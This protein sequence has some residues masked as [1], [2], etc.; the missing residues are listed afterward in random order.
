MP[1][2][3]VNDQFVPEGGVVVGDDGSACSAEAVRV[4]AQDAARRG[5]PLHIVRC[6][7]MRTAPSPD[8]ATP[9]YV[10]PLSDWEAAVR[11]EM[12][13]TWGARLTRDAPGVPVELHPVHAKPAQALVTAS[14][15]ADLVV[16]GFRGRGG[17]RER[18]LGSVAAHV[19]H[20][21]ACPVLLV[22]WRS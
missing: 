18:L 5:C 8:T 11:A 1:G 2:S 3:R 20:H 21:A 22:R 14:T 17:R 12:Q 15:G 19:V 4:A 10:P 7:S 13:R 16:V 6:W 9:G